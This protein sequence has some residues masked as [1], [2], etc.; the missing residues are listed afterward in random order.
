MGHADYKQLKHSKIQLFSRLKL[1]NIFSGEWDSIY[2]G[3]GI[4]F[5]D[6]KPF[7]P[8]DDL[9]D[10][11]LITLLQSG[12]EEIIRRE[13][14]R[15][16]KIFVWVDFSGS[17]QR[18]EDLFFFSRPDIRD[19]AIGL[20]IYSACNA[21]SP[22][23]L[24][25]FDDKIRE[26]LPAKYGESYCDKIMDRILDYDYRNTRKMANIP[27]ALS[28]MMEKVYKQSMV[29]FISD[30]KD[31]VF[32]GDF[33]EL[34][35][36]ASRKFDFI[37]VVIRDPIEKDV[38]LKRSLNISVKDS[39]GNGKSEIYLTPA[40]LHE[41]QRISTKHIE[42]LEQNF[43]RAGIDYALLDSPSIDDCYQVLSGFFVGRKRIRV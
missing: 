6:I 5:A 20:I 32:E 8:G 18:N 27:A 36:P 34:L 33:T 10:L 22:T 4:E 12:E 29:F 28:F 42:H 24:C 19:I 35:R 25:I 3:E 17:M 41:M 1:K 21:Y 16:M 40:R 30:F 14:G 9:R 26:F 39:E 31:P 7:E 2:V 15:Q 11:D 23:G 13:V 37:P 38:I 43:Y